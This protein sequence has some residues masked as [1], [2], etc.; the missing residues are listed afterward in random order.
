MITIATT[1][2]NVTAVST[3][4]ISAESGVLYQSVGVH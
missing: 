1:Y 3:P 4:T 2:L